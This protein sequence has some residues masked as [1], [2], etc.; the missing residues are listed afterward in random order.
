MASTS[1]SLRW[2]LLGAGLVITPLF[3]EAQKGGPVNFPQLAAPMKSSAGRSRSGPL[4]G[5]GR[6]SNE[7]VYQ[8][9]SGQATIANG[10]V[11]GVKITN[12]GYYSTD[13]QLGVVFSGGGGS[14]ATGT[15]EVQ[16]RYRGAEPST[17][18]WL[19]VNHI[20]ITNPGSGYT[21][22]PTVTF[23]VQ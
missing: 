8:K 12:R 20:H 1:R 16:R 17:I 2:L 9:A 21:N 15:V 19:E 23:V 14:G 10:Q 4:I 7:T 13:T 6:K 5:D 3:T 18:F 11:I 22:P